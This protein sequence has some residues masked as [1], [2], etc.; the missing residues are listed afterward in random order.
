MEEKKEGSKFGW[1]V[2]GFF[3]PIVGLILF[4]VWLNS[5][6]KASKAAGIGAL[7]GTG[8]SIVLFLLTIF[9]VF[10]LLNSSNLISR[11]L[12]GEKDILVQKALVE[13][14]DYSIYDSK[15]EMDWSDNFL[16]TD[17]RNYNA[18]DQNGKK[19][20]TIQE[21]LIFKNNDMIH[22]HKLITNSGE[23]LS[24]DE[25]FPELIYDKYKFYYKDNIVIFNVGDED[26][27]YYFY[28]L[29][30][31]KLYHGFVDDEVGNEGLRVADITMDDTSITFVAEF[32]PADV[33]VSS[34]ALIY[35][36]LN[37]GEYETLE[38]LKK[39]IKALKL[40]D[41][42][43]SKKITFS[44]KDGSYSSEPSIEKKT[45][46]DLYNEKYNP[47]PT[48]NEKGACDVKAVKEKD[49]LY[50]VN[51][52]EGCKTVKVLDKEENKLF[53]IDTEA[54]KA[55][56][57]NG[58][59]LE[60]YDNN[61]FMYVDNSVILYSAVCSPGYC[62]VYV[63]NTNDNTGF[64]IK[65]SVEKEDL[66][67]PYIREIKIDDSKNLVLDI[68]VNESSGFEEF[69]DD[70]RV[71]V[72]GKVR[73]CEISDLEKELKANNLDK[74]A[75]S[76]TYT[77]N[78]ENGNIVNKPTIKVKDTIEDLYNSFASVCSR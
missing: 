59:E 40:E 28:D 2:L 41:F 47:T 57:N 11:K 22:T 71:L 33:K 3:F 65:P 73:T 10:G 52:T 48:P 37:N 36:K 15:Y 23:E 30:N 74:F 69:R 64:R 50:N 77:Y 46:V 54:K 70:P 66:M 63:Y 7:I 12:T 51:Y 53:E 78:N 16:T 60:S 68:K 4:L 58:E 14:G 8:V 39:N 19:L 24:F 44:K 21:T 32:N 42:T 75:I 1:G 29:D 27:G 72:I 5:K 9:G 62:Y 20:F 56:T 38:D 61:K 25:Y 13:A 55:L 45:I 31:R 49:Y 34:N 43:V 67:V 26:T 18:V 35:K 76:K 6:K 17:I